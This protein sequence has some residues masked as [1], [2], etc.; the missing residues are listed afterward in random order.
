M[1]IYRKEL[2]DGT[3][4]NEKMEDGMHIPFSFFLAYRIK[5]GADRVRYAAAEYPENGSPSDRLYGGLRGDDYTPSDR[6][7]AYH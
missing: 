7:V 3:C 5:D 1:E 4:N 6:D 2:Q